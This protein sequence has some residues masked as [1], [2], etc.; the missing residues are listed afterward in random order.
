M[1]SRPTCWPTPQRWPVIKG[2]DSARKGRVADPSS[3][4]GKSGSFRYL[5]LYIE[6]RGRIFL[7]LLLSKNEQANLSP[8]QV[9]Q[10][11]EMVE[12]IKE[13]NKGGRYESG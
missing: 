7:L 11:A 12:R 5:Y 10:V 8:H 2:T 13:A 4:R 6:H 9:R 1:Q 3:S